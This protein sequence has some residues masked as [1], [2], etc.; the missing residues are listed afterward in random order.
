MTTFTAE[1]LNARDIKMVEV[2]K[3][4]RVRNEDGD[5]LL[6]F[7]PKGRDSQDFTNMSR[8][9]LRKLLN[10]AYAAGFEAASQ[11]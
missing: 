3:D 4:N 9:K 10:D 11:E 7:K 5:L 6:D 2:L 8:A 1:Q